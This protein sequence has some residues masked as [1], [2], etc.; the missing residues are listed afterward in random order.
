MCKVTRKASKRDYTEESGI[1]TANTLATRQPTLPTEPQSTPVH[2]CVIGHH[3]SPSMA[4]NGVGAA[5][6]MAAAQ[7]VSMYVNG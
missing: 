4:P 2:H 3:T 6:C 1:R 5:P 7:L